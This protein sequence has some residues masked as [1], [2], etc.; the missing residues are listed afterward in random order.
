MEQVEGS[1]TLDSQV[2]RSI[3]LF[4]GISETAAL[5]LAA[6]M[7]PLK[8]VRGE[9]L[10]RQG[11]SGDKAYIIRNG[12]IKLGNT[13]ADG[14]ENLLTVLGN[15]ELLGELT[16]FDLGPRTATATAVMRTEVMELSHQVLTDWLA[17]NPAAALTIL[18][19]FA[20]RLRRTNEALSDLIFTD[21]P[22]RIAKALIDLA[23]RFGDAR[24][25]AVHVMHG[26]TQEELAQL[27]GASRE[28]VNKAL[29]EFVARGWVRL[30]GRGVYILDVEQLSKRSR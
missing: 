6:S 23:E 28:T 19:S 14:R 30:E 4:S 5:E 26:L 15:G 13:A 20:R 7:T 27:I 8:L 22:G 25:G 18:A 12:K 29:G 3:G 17:A 10:F 9:V 11:E 16:V 2:I 21:V 1:N 24:D